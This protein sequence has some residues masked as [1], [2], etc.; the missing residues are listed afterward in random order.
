M[1]TRLIDGQTYVEES[2]VFQ[3]KRERLEAWPVHQ[4]RMRKLLAEREDQA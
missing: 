1:P 4:Y 3:W 2:I